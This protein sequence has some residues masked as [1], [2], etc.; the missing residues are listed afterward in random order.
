MVQLLDAAA[1][2]AAGF[3]AGT[4]N[5]VVGSGSLVTFPTLLALGYPPLTANI[6]NNIG[7]VAGGMTAVHGYRSELTGQRTRLRRLVPMSLVGS[8]TGALL[9]LRLPAEAFRTIV[10][11]L[12]GAAVLLVLLQ[13][14]I[15][16]RVARRQAVLGTPGEVTE[17]PAGP[18]VMAGVF[19]A[20]VYGGYFGAA[21]GVVLVGLLGSL[22]AE[23]L[24]RANALKNV[25]AL[26]VNA[27]AA[28][29]F[30]LVAP[31]Q[32]DWAVVALISVGSLVGGSGGAWVGRRLPPDVLRAVIAIIGVVA[33]I[34]LLGS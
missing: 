27:V 14:R 7:L 30:T 21:Q 31:D 12:V 15:A 19:G 5:A 25:L 24:Q 26:G 34:R 10:P 3:A 17:V 2:V 20:G 16:A 32:V 9:L 13:P 1:I 11:V 22:L 8:V 33:V 28:L 23:R 18:L 29:T 6:S 4:I